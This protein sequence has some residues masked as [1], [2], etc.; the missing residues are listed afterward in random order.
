MK[1]KR[2][3]FDDTIY[4]F[5]LIA[6]QILNSFGRFV[7]FNS[8]LYSHFENH[9][10]PPWCKLRYQ[11]EVPLEWWKVVQNYLSC[12]HSPEA[13]NSNNTRSN[14]NKNSNGLKGN[15]SGHKNKQQNDKQK[16]NDCEKKE[17]QTND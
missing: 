2:N 3:C 5:G 7:L 12:W 16:H 9:R 8:I 17:G 14:K 6:I 15:N 10:K 11:L 4:F 13:D 1:T